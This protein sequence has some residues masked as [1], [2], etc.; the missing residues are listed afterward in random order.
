MYFKFYSLFTLE[1]T[2]LDFQIVF[3]GMQKLVNWLLKISSYVY[4]VAWICESV[5]ALYGKSFI[6]ILSRFEGVIHLYERVVHLHTHMSTPFVWNVIFT[7]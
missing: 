4:F 1:A 3:N 6:Y 7:R 5:S 2:V